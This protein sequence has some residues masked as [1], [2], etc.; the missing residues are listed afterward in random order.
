M[1]DRKKFTRSLPWKT[2]DVNSTIVGDREDVW[3]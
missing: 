2:E 1:K 3:V